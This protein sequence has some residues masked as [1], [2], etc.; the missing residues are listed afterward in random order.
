MLE[1]YHTRPA[2]H[3]NGIVPVTDFLP[4]GAVGPLYLA[5]GLLAFPGGL[6]A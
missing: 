3:D 6:V 2:Y 5:R 4:L 1:C